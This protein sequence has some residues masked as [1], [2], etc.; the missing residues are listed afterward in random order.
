MSNDEL[1]RILSQAVADDYEE[2]EMIFNEIVKWT[3]RGGNDTPDTIQRLAEARGIKL[4]RSG[5]ELIGLCPLHD[6]RLS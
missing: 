2:L 5:K 1:R 3:S 6:D 4:H